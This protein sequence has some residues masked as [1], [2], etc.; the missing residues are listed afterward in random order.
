MA[1]QTSPVFGA[2][3][4]DFPSSVYANLSTIAPNDADG[5]N[6]PKVIQCNS[7]AIKRTWLYFQSVV[8]ENVGKSHIR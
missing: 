7:G 1:D 5:A 4:E 2:L 8:H 3:P 6:V